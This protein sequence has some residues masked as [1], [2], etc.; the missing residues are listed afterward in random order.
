MIALAF[1]AINLAKYLSFAEQA[2]QKVGLAAGSWSKQYGDAQN[3]CRGLGSGA[4][5]TIKYVVP[6][7]KVSYRGILSPDGVY[8]AGSHVGNLVAIDARTGAQ[9]G[10]VHRAS[11][12]PSAG[13]LGANGLVYLQSGT[14]ST[15]GELFAIDANTG[16]DRWTYPTNSLFDSPP[17]IG[18]DGTVYVMSFTN[19]LFA[20][21]GE[22]G[23]LKWRIK[24]PWSKCCMAIGPDGSIYAGGNFEVVN[25]F[26][27]RT[28]AL[29]WSKN[30]QYCSMSAPA[31]GDDGTVFIRTEHFLVALDGATG[32]IKW[33][34]D[35]MNPKE[36]PAIGYDGNV[37][38]GT[39]DGKIYG[40]NGK[41]GAQLWKIDPGFGTSFNDA[42]AID[43]KGI[44][45]L[46]S[47]TSVEGKVYAVDTVTG[48]VLWTVS[49]KGGAAWGPI[50]G[51]DGTLY[52]I[53][54]GSDL[55]AIH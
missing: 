36:P 24:A 46:I 16:V 55:A 37:Y 4:T 30:F 32:D 10:Q 14:S 40:L 26:H 19:E 20:L 38:F 42:G 15:T 39:Q 51:P 29:K 45:Y 44:L 34:F 41:T 23:Q 5:G 31:V 27:P 8:F 48:K 6:L 1:A 3:T 50:L 33:K 49:P 17:T 9:K 43:P 18:K 2:T 11:S 7:D 54:G 21:N 53:T 25:C 13:A 12:L 35:C 22:N 52:V 47:R 28:G